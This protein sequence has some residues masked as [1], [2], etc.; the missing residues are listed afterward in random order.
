VTAYQL[1]TYLA[2]MCWADVGQLIADRRTISLA[3]QLYRAIGSVG[4]NLAEGYSL[5]TGPNRARFYEYSLGS[6]REARDWYFKARHVLDPDV[7]TARLA[8]LER[9]IQLLLAAIPQQRALRV[10]DE[11]ADYDAMPGIGTAEQ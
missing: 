7:V 3:D 4:A 9:I 6:A 11:G 2:D 10:R 1:A 8:L 5:G